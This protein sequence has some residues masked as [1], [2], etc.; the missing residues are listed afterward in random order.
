VDDDHQALAE[1]GEGGFD[2]LDL[3]LAADEIVSCPP[4]PDRLALGI[5]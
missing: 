1:G 4:F 2:V 5:G 3:D